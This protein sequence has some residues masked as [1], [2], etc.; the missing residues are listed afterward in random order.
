ML[1]NSEG[2][3]KNG[4]PR[5]T[6][7]IRYSRRIHLHQKHNTMCV[8]HHCAHANTNDVTKTC[9]LNWRLRQTEYRFHE[10][11]VTDTTSQKSE[12]NDR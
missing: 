4:Q 5:E 7:N 10:L 12:R 11:I 9:A 8:G 3:I 1:E 2:T 6:G